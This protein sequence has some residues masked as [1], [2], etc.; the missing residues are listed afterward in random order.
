MKA[1]TYFWGSPPANLTM[2]GSEVHIWSASLDQPAIA[3]RRL[4]R[5][6][7]AAEWARADRLRFERDRLRF[8]VGRGLLR[9]ILGRYLNLEPGRV[10]FHYNT[11]G[12]PALANSSD[13]CQIGSHSDLQFNLAHSHGLALYAV[14]RARVV[15]VDLERIRPIAEADQVVERHF[16]AQERAVYHALPSDEQRWTWFNCWTCKE[17]Y[18]KARGQGL[19]WPLHEIEV[20]VAPWEWKRK[21]MRLL[22]V[23]GDAQEASRWSIRMLSPAPGY[24]ATLAVSGHDWQL[25]CWHWDW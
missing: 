7:S 13:R 2:S 20:S 25:K 24:A 9:T 18:L 6:L 23:A 8:I 22:R 3:I 14:A 19:Q 12:K 4:A 11:Y 10:R 17:A 21:T 15:G 16:S 1:F 5:T